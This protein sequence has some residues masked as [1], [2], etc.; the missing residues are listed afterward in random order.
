MIML[1]KFTM[2]LYISEETFSR[3]LR[4]TSSSGPLTLT[5]EVLEKLKA[6]HPQVSEVMDECLLQGPVNFVPPGIFYVIDEQKIHEAAM[7][8]KGSAGPL[9]MDVELYR[10]IKCS[11]NFS[12]VGKKLREE[13][14]ILTRKLLTTSFIHLSLK[15]T[16]PPG[17]FHS[18]RI[19]EF[20]Q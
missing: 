17:L 19:P 8:T 1:P 9:G 5:P 12:T 18:T 14:S 2:K 6:K 15:A 3:Y 11:R 16:Q 13:I 20:D 4:E 10:R 7:K